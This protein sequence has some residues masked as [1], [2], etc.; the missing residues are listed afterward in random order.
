MSGVGQTMFSET[1]CKIHV[2]VEISQTD[3]INTQGR[4]ESIQ[5]QVR[6]GSK[7][8]GPLVTR[9]KDSDV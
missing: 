1:S 2:R 9:Q 6:S 5:R 7:G 3:L 8:K 4:T